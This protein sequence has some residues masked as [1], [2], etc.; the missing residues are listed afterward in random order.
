[1]LEIYPQCLKKLQRIGID[2]SK[3]TQFAL[4]PTS[5]NYG[6]LS[7]LYLKK[8]NGKVTTQDVIALNVKHIKDLEYGKESIE[9]LIFH[10]LTHTF[11]QGFEFKQLRSNEGDTIWSQLNRGIHKFLKDYIGCVANEMITDRI[12]LGLSMDR[13]DQ[14]FV[15]HTV[16]DS[17]N[18]VLLLTQL[19]G[20]FEEQERG[21]GKAL[22]LAT[23][24]SSR[25]CK[26]YQIA[27][28][29]KHLR[30]LLNIS[31]AEFKKDF[32][33][34]GLAQLDLKTLRDLG[35]TI[36]DEI[37]DET[38]SRWPYN[39]GY[40]SSTFYKSSNSFATPFYKTVQN[41]TDRFQLTKPQS[42]E[43]VQLKSWQYGDSYLETL[44]DALTLS[45]KHFREQYL[46]QN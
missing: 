44:E 31:E 30:R 16:H 6:G 19:E 39:D 9:H 8:S 25:T 46:V 45:P 40:M 37:K 29:N 12:A 32:F 2:T 22:Q 4:L 24:L 11:M 41:I 5:R 1:L 43:E 3:H 17:R 34:H 28:I 23:I 20:F 18:N 7:D 14:S 15:N 27:F 26:P 21:L 33:I 35:S 10:E 38:K 13:P 42:Y 36:P